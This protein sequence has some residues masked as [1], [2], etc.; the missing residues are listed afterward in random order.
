MHSD[1]AS[2]L[3]LD[4]LKH[5]VFGWVIQTLSNLC[6]C[7]R[8]KSEPWAAHPEA[9]GH[10]KSYGAAFL[11]GSSKEYRW[12]SQAQVPVLGYSACPKIK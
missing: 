5:P 4:Y 7:A 10:P 9:A 3:H 6:M 1:V 11:P 8:F 2:R 12:G